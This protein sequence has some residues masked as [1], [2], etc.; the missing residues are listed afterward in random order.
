MR[1]TQILFL[2]LLISFVFFRPGFGQGSKPL[3]I[4]DTDI[5]E[6]VDEG[7]EPKP[8]E[9]NPELAEKNIQIGDFYYKR[10]N[11]SAAISRY[12]T[13]IEYQSD[14]IRAYESLAK[15]YEK[16]GKLPKAMDAIKDFLRINPGSPKC[17]DF[18]KMLANLEEK[19]HQTDN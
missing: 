3:I 6:G 7:E 16:E 1:L 10:K 5:A 11:Y 2:F 15:A 12:L 14:S 13:A 17:D 19:S 4:R 18:R 8:K 9:R